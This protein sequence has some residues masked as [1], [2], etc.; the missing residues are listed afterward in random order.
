M[1]KFCFKGRLSL[2]SPNCL[3][4][5]VNQVDLNSEIALPLPPGIK[6]MHHHT[7][8]WMQFFLIKIKHTS[9][10][11]LN[12]S[13]WWD[14]VSKSINKL[15][16]RL[17]NHKLSPLQLGE[18][19]GSPGVEMRA[20]RKRSHFPSDLLPLTPM[21]SPF[22]PPPTVNESRLETLSPPTPRA[23]DLSFLFRRPECQAS[24][25][26]RLVPCDGPLGCT[27]THSPA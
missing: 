5:P 2:C 9:P 25:S 21:R 22:P 20:T 1:L 7:W 13:V 15:P 26:F 18:A 6:A 10:H 23:F 16:E 4:S 14:M 11:T 19:S 8:L 12:P 27:G 24:S 3:G 17:L